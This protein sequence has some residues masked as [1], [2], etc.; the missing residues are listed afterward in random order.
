VD[1]YRQRVVELHD[2]RLK[3]DEKRGRYVIDGEL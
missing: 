2:G 3:R 1:A